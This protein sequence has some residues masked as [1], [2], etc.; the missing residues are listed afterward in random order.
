MAY[1]ELMCMEEHKVESPAHGNP[2]SRLG[3]LAG[4][5]AVESSR[6]RIH[7]IR[8]DEHCVQLE[9]ALVAI[10]AYAGHTGIGRGNPEGACCRAAAALLRHAWQLLARAKPWG[11][12]QHSMMQDPHGGLEDAV[13]EKHF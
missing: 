2:R 4:S 1:I 3:M 9:W 6:A 13:K 7:M 8:R 11:A 12:T 5:Y 10:P